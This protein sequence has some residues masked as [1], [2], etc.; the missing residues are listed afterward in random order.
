MKRVLFVCTANICRSPAAEAIFNALVADRGMDYR[1]ESA[2]VAALEGRTTAKETA[3]ALEEV[4][5]YAG[6][7]RAR[8][9]S[10]LMVEEADLVLAMNGGHVE[11]AR[12]LIGTLPEYAHVLPE[13]ATGVPGSSISD[14]YGYTMPAHRATVRHILECVEAVLDRLQ[15]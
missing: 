6:E 12:T 2:G 14:P 13:Y 3:A 10:R 1:A 15:E 9:V 4:G 7:H 8:Q 5:I 11:R